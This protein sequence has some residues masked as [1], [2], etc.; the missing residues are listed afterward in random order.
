MELCGPEL[1]FLGEGDLE[2]ES[3]LDEELG[4]VVGRGIDLRVG[5]D[6]VIGMESIVWVGGIMLVEGSQL[7]CEGIKVLIF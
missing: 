3:I 7:L 1:L 5:S 4:P 2:L 6:I